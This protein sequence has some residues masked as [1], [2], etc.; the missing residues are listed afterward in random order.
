VEA[1]TE[2]CPEDAPEPAEPAP[3]DPDVELQPAIRLPASATATTSTQPDDLEN[4][5]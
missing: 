4:M 3:L 2:I 1:T 5:W